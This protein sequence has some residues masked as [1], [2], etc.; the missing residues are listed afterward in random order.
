MVSAAQIR[1]GVVEYANAHILPKLTPGKQFA[2]GTALGIAAARA[3]ELLRS[4]AE[5][6]II[7]ATG[8]I[9]ENG[10][11]D[12]DALYNAALTQ[13]KRQKTLPVDIPFIGKLTFDETDITEL[14]R[15]ISAR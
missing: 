11:V 12:L 15:T 1:D 13:L 7:K 10:M 5:N 4:L 6:D 3:E 2:A 8:I 9:A 14:Y